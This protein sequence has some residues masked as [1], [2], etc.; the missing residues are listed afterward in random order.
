[1]NLVK[2]VVFAASAWVALAGPGYAQNV[3]SN[4]IEAVNVSGQGADIAVKID[5]KD[6]LT[7][8]PPGFAVANPAKFAFDFSATANGL[9]RTSEVLNQGDLR[10]MNVVQVADRTRLVLNLVRT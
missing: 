6:A 4:A 5:L 9:G 8:P 1:M 7:T 10:S 2:Y 3:A